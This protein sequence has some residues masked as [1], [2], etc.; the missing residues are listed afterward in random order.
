MPGGV[1]DVR[2]V[3]GGWL[4]VRYSG[5]RRGIG[6]IRGIGAH[7]DAGGIGESGV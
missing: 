6:G 4:G 3:L 7:R 2:G 1:G 5:V